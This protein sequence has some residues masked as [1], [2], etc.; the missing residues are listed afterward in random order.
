MDFITDIFTDG[1]KGF[2]S[3]LLNEALGVFDD[4]LGDIV[5]IALN[6]QGYM[7]GNFNLNFDDLFKIINS[8]A[9]YLIVL[10]F[11]KKG[12]DTY[13]LWNDGDADMD[14]FIL[15]TG[16]F[17]AIIVAISFDTIYGFIV[18]IATDGINQM[19]GSINT[20]AV[21]KDAL[22]AV[23]TG[24][25]AKGLIMIIIAIVYFILYIILW[26]Q[27]IKRGLE[28]FILKAGIPFACVGMIDS[29]GGV[30]KTY[31][32]KIIQEVF[33]VLVQTFVLKLSLV[34]M[35]NGNFMFGIA[36]ILMSMK[37]PQFLSE[38]IMMSSGGQGVVQK[39][40]QTV[41]T[42]SMIRSFVS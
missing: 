17:K 37:A 35:I 24:F 18:D 38:F 25:L 19:I 21:D 31:V 11:L 4:F 7:S 3:N 10:K 6:A 13:I 40:S 22:Y 27:F 12:F 8:F 2:L 9:L 28:L 36:A 14:P 32:K 39:A 5:D 29:D 41:H 15:C 23:I 33:T 16:F 34:F 30:F 1:I 26:L 42:A 20:L